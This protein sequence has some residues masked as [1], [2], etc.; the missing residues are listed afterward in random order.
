MSRLKSC[1]FTAIALLAG[2]AWHITPAQAAS[3]ANPNP[4]DWTVARTIF[5]KNGEDL[6]LRV[7][8]HDLGDIDGFGLRHISD[9][10]DGFVPDAGLI[11]DA[12]DTCDSNPNG[13]TTC[14]ITDSTG[15]R[16]IVVWTGRIDSRSPDGRPVGIITAYYP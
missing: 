14:E 5:G 2:F 11:Q 6:P 15:R 13:A 12:A 10:H 16:F 4:I 7:G 3:T 1:T 8:Q 9:G